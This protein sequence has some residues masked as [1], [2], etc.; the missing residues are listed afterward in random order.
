VMVTNADG[1]TTLQTL[2]AL[3]ITSI[4]LIS[5]NQQTVEADGSTIVGTT[6]Y[7]RSNSTTGKAGDAKLI[8]DSAGYV[9]AQTVTHNGDGST[10]VENRATDAQETSSTIPSSRPPPTA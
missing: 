1:T 3:G 5:N 8:S 2:S 9:V 6:T 7:T 10:S 4:D